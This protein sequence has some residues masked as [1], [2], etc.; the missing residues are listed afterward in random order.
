M[1]TKHSPRHILQAQANQITNALKAA[2]RGHTP[3]VRFAEK[4]NAARGKESIKVGVVMDDKVITLDLPWKVIRETRD[5][6]LADY[7][8]NLML[9]SRAST[10][11]PDGR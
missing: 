6:G 11:G 3:D 1:T 8:L 7:I 10:G 2:E 4:I 5:A 9:E